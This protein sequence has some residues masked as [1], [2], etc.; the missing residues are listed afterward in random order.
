MSLEWVLTVYETLPSTSDECKKL[1]ESG[2]LSGTAI[3]A[4]TQT[5]GRGTHGRTWESLEGNLAF[6][7]IMRHCRLEEI[8]QILPFVVAVSLYDAMRF[9]V[10]GASLKI[11][12]PNDLVHEGAKLA[13]TLIERGGHA[14]SSW[15]VVGIGANL[16]TAPLIET[17]KTTC[18]ARLGGAVDPVRL[19]H[20]I[21]ENVAY[22]LACWERLGFAPIRDAWLERGH[23]L[24]SRLAARRGNTY[25]PGFFAGLDDDGRLLLQTEQHGVQTFTAGD[26]ILLG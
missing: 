23:E 15:V 12:W 24:G 8:T 16:A 2:A 10:P 19:A 4:R 1:A 13:G 25:I 22:W 14:A 6:S 17:Q 26:V 5:S 11:K 7:F 21:L 9:F 20:T 3:V 18:L